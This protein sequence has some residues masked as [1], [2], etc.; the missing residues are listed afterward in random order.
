MP[1]L[2]SSC[3][4][5]PQGRCLM[6]HSIGCCGL[7][8]IYVCAA[9]AFHGLA[10]ME[11]FLCSAMHVFTCLSVSPMCTLS[12]TRIPGLS[13]NPCWAARRQHASNDRH[14]CLWLL[15]IHSIKF[16]FNFSFI[17]SCHV[18]I[19][20][21]IYSA[22][23]STLHVGPKRLAVSTSVPRVLRSNHSPCYHIRTWQ[24]ICI[25]P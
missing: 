4:S 12:H 17:T 3:T 2:P 25:A 11:A 15:K 13:L 1:P 19:A 9:M 6:S 10:L 23:A 14:W 5:C 21:L 20:P 7:S 8:S 22:D 16:Q 24:W 18:H